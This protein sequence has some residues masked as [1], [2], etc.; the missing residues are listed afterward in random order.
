MENNIDFDRMP[1][2][3]WSPTTKMS[4]LQ[5]RVLVYSMMYYEY[6]ESC[7]SDQFYDGI[8]KQLVRLQ[9]RYPDEFKETEY[10]YAMY[11]FDGTTGFDLPDRLNDSDKNRIE[12]ISNVIYRKWKRKR[13]KRNGN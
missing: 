13:R 4:Y 6:N 7:V 12:L 1:S 9:K 5:R 2:V 3:Y 8:S 11:D 10:Y